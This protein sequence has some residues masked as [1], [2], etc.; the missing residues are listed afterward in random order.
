MKKEKP[1]KAQAGNDGQEKF[2]FRGGVKRRTN[3]SKDI[4][5]RFRI[6]LAKTGGK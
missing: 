3:V 2:T 1:P 4:L 6:E 5:T